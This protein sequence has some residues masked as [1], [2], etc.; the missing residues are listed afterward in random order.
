[1]IQRRDVLSSEI[2]E[3]E[4]ML[5]G[6]PATAVIQR[7]SLES[8]LKSVRDAFEQELACCQ[9]SYVSLTKTTV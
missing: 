8:R 3:L 5:D 6:I 2:R 4:Q 9:P 1:M 7:I